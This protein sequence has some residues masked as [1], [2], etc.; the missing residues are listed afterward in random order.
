M[1]LSQIRRHIVDRASTT[2]QDWLYRQAPLFGAALAAFVPRLYQLYQLRWQGGSGT[3]GHGSTA[4]CGLDERLGHPAVLWAVRV[5]SMATV[6][7]LA[8]G[9]FRQ[10][11]VTEYT[12]KR[13]Y[14]YSKYFAVRFV[15]RLYCLY[16]LVLSR[17]GCSP[18]E[19]TP[20]TNKQPTRPS[21]P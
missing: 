19:L 11:A 5:V 13:R 8:L 3:G 6:F 10:L 7:S 12:Y 16:G 1:T 15:F 21:P 2:Q 4:V 17:V 20:Q 18:T 14:K 9:M